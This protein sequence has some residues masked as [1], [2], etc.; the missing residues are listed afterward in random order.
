[1]AEVLMIAGLFLYVLPTAVA[2]IRDKRNAVA[3]MALNL[4]LG[5]TLVGW[6]IALIWS[7][8]VDEQQATK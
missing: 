3:I 1:M 2:M 5:W 6:V 8:T 7:L 4:L